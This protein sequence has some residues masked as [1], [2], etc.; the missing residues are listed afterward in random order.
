LEYRLNSMRGRP[1]GRHHSQ[2]DT[3]LLEY[4]AKVSMKYEVDPDS[5]FNDLLDVYQHGKS[6]CKKLSIDCRLRERDHAIFLM[7]EGRKVVGQ[8]RISEQLLSEKINPLKPFA[9]RLS[10]MR[11]LSQ[12]TR[13]KSC[14]IADLKAG[15]KR[16]NVSARVLKVSQPIQILTRS[17]FHASLA[18]ALIA[19]ET[20][21]INLSLF[22]SQIREVTLRDVIQ[23]ENS[24]VAWFRGERQ[25]RIGRHGKI[26]LMNSAANGVKMEAF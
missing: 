19:D 3:K 4:L 21:T 1:S 7:T 25:L 16:L 15:M 22:G 18:I 10:A 5:F 2:E 20:G 23:V 26:S 8:F 6:K 17:G 12:G 9:S 11:N 24:H 14:K 13:T